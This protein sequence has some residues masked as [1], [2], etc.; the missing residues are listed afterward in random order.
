MTSLLIGEGS[1]DNSIGDN[2]VA[3]MVANTTSL[4]DQLARKI[5]KIGLISKGDEIVI[6]SEN[7]LANVTTWLSVAKMVGAKIRWWTV[8]NDTCR[9]GRQRQEKAESLCILSD[10]INAK[11]KVVAI[12]HVSNILGQ[13]R[14][15]E[16][17]CNLVRRVTSNRG[18]VVVDGVAAAPHLLCTGLSSNGTAA[19]GGPDWYVVSLHTMF[20]PHLGCLV[21]EQSSVVDM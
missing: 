15:V 20:G 9:D 4:L 19:G 5:C 8:T 21:G 12:S 6:A 10:L 18:Q 14:D 16:S 13:T 7:H 2:V 1:S 3:I 17:A 11:T